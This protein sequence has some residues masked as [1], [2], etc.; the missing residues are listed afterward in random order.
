[1]VKTSCS[2]FN[3]QELLLFVFFLFRMFDNEYL[4]FDHLSTALKGK[5]GGGQ[6]FGGLTFDHR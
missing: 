2:E 1:M 4:W 3:S 6:I 5:D